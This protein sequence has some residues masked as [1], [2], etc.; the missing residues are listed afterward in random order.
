[1]LAIDSYQ[2]VSINILDLNGILINQIVNKNLHPG[3]YNFEWRPDNVSNGIYFIVVNNGMEN[4]M[5]K[6]TFIK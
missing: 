2:P 6:V 1:M 4:I 5:K 3:I